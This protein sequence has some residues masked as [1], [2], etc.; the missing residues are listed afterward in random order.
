[1]LTESTEVL[2]RSDVA[3][4]PSP[5]VQKQSTLDPTAWI[6]T[7][8]PSDQR[9]RIGVAHG[10]IDILSEKSNFPIASERTNLSGLDYLALGDWHGFLQQGRAVY[11]GTLE[12]ASFNERDSGNIAIVDIAKAGGEP[13]ITKLHVGKLTWSEYNPLIS[14]VTD[15]EQ[16]RHSI[17]GVGAAEMQLFRIMSEIGP[18][19]SILALSELSSL[20]EELLKEV[21]FL[22]WPEDT[23]RAPTGTAIPIPDGLLTQVDSN[24]NAILERRIPDGPGHE[25]ASADL[26]VV[27]EAKSLMRRLAMEV[28]K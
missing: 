7:R 28:S 20:R 21:L 12:Q 10:A 9:F 25:F 23:I 27:R 8:K 22:D 6:P 24:L 5:L 1:L 19:V 16:L 11:S 17:A 2:I 4:Y 15:V 14:D 26:N 13:R 18:E 3:L